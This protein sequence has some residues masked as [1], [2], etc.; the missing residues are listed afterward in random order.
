MD[1]CVQWPEPPQNPEKLKILFNLWVDVAWNI[2]K[3]HAK[4]APR[5]NLLIILSDLRLSLSPNGNAN[6]YR[7]CTFAFLLRKRSTGPIAFQSFSLCFRLE[8]INWL[9]LAEGKKSRSLIKPLLH[10]RPSLQ[11]AH[12]S[13]GPGKMDT[14]SFTV[15]GTF[16]AQVFTLHTLSVCCD[17]WWHL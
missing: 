11:L 1:V 15:V 5:R 6:L 9:S 17:C 2:T 16:G 4:C 13:S 10:V 12:L 8:Q 14:W 3:S 7:S